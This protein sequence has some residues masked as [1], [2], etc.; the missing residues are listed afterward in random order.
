MRLTHNITSAAELEYLG[1]TSTSDYC[2]QTKKSVPGLVLGRNNTWTGTNIFNNSINFGSNSHFVLTQAYG[3]FRLGP[4]AASSNTGLN[5][6]AIVCLDSSGANASVMYSEGLLTNKK[7]IFGANGS[8]QTILLSGQ[9]YKGLNIKY[10]NSSNSE[11][12]LAQFKHSGS[13]LNSPLDM[14]TYKISNLGNPVFAGDAVNKTYVDSAVAAAGGS[15]ELSTL[16]GATKILYGSDGTS[17]SLR[18]RNQADTDDTF[19]INTDGNIY[20]HSYITSIR[21]DGY[22][23]IQSNGTTFNRIQLRHW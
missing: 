9:S 16:Y 11:E 4:S 15:T 7:L 3:V 14:K 8:T 21:N 12:L 20:T 6:G 5:N 13:S 10:V 22:L 1:S 19:K 18:V 17:P 23:K 2:V